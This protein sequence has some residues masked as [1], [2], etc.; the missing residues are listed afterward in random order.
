MKEQESFIS[1]GYRYIR[2]N[3][4]W[5]TEH[6]VI[7]EKILGRPL[8][9]AIVVHHWNGNK[10]D[11]RN[12]NLLICSQSYHSWLHQEMSHRYQREHFTE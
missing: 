2:H 3:G 5:M 1:R 8:T 7:A 10:L 11:N 9:K 4:K 6:T 12:S